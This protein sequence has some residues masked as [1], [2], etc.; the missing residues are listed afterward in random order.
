MAKKRPLTSH[1]PAY[2]T[3]VADAPTELY[4]PPPAK[5]GRRSLKPLILIGMLIGVAALLA[6]LLGG[7]ALIYYSDWVLPGVS[8]AG[9]NLGSRT[10]EEAAAVLAEQWSQRT[11]VLEAEG[12]AWTVTPAELGIVLDTAVTAQRAH[13]YGR[14]PES[15]WQWLKAGGQAEIAPAWTID[16]AAAE[17]SL[18]GLAAQ[19]AVPPQNAGVEWDGFRFQATPAVDG[20]AMDVPSTLIWLEQS[21][22]QAV[23]TS[24]LQLPTV[25]VAPAITDVSGLVAAANQLLATAVTI[26]AYDP[27]RDETMNWMV[28]PE[29][30]GR[31]LT[32][33]VDPS[34]PGQFEWTLDENQAQAFLAAQAQSLGE[35]R[36]VDVNG[37]VT[38]VTE[39]IKVQNTAVTLRI[40]HHPTQ[41]IV[42]AGETFASIGRA[43]GM[44]YPW[45]QQANPGVSDGLFAGQVLTIP[46]PDEMLPLPVVAN[47]RIIVSISQQRMWAYE[48]GALIWDWPA[49]TGIDDSPTSPGVFQIQTHES[50]A[51]AGNWNLWMPNFMGIYRPVPTS[52]FM[53]GFHGFPT[54]DGQN[55]LWTSSL[56]HQVTYGCILVSTENSR[57]L[58]DWAEA[59]VVVEIRP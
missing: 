13:E 52:D 22:A 19:F 8:T 24:K 41:H 29:Q 20:Q 3:S 43:Y 55:L 18:N 34:A 30:W 48:N 27:V 37:L 49:S 53:N 45:I 59:G 2:A 10:T 4:I 16:L 9:V 56:G 38:A 31:W 25:P 1:Q 50:N 21:A 26:Q 39:A 40:Y 12:A 15:L 5:A 44:P 57:F 46:S 6:L 47:K 36:Y 11:I 32:P 23:A 54:R 17:V 28:A 58:Y 51:Y 35:D 42:Q 14:S 33:V 7:M